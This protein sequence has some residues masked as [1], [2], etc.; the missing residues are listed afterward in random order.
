MLQSLN[1]KA[2]KTMSFMD[3]PIGDRNCT[4]WIGRQSLNHG[5]PREVQKSVVKHLGARHWTHSSP[6]MHPQTTQP[7][8]PLSDVTSVMLWKGEAV[9]KAC[10]CEVEGCEWRMIKWWKRASQ[11]GYVVIAFWR[12]C[13]LCVTGPW[14]LNTSVIPQSLWQP[15]QLSSPPN[16]HI[17]THT[18][19]NTLAAGSDL[20]FWPSQ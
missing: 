9:P 18:H 10:P 13:L 6:G 7:P 5:T 12:R 8:Q 20:P 15:I 11:I 1:P 16:T 3:P 2:L 19:P 17:H 4:P 14:K